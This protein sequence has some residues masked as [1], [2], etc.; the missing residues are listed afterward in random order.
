VC[1]QRVD[2]A[3]RVR[4]RRAIIRDPRA[5]HAQLARANAAEIGANLTRTRRESARVRS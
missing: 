3:Q 2:H 5:D 4:S 1:S